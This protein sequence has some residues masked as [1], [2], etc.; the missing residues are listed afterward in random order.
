VG[1]STITS[2]L[3][4]ILISI[5]CQSLKWDLLVLY[6]LSSWVLRALSGRVPIGAESLR[7]LYEKYSL[8]WAF[9]FR[10]SKLV[11]GFIPAGISDPVCVLRI[12]RDSAT[13]P[14]QVVFHR[15]NF[16]VYHLRGVYCAI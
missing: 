2:P 6:T 10:E 4:R 5:S 9:Q 8:L 3:K 12:H 16:V 15:P 14:M 1:S 13:A 11:F 7:Y